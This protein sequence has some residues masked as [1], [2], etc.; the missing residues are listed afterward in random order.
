M[1][2]EPENVERAYGICLTEKLE[3][4]TTAEIP[5]AT[6]ATKKIHINSHGR[7]ILNAGF[8]RLSR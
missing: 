3:V 8:D 6:T 1:V 4:A 2:H 7:Y 5:T